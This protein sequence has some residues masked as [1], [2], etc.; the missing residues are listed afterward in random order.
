MLIKCI[1][2]SQDPIEKI[3][4]YI[5]F[6]DSG[7]SCQSGYSDHNFDD[8][9]PSLDNNGLGYNNLTT[10]VLATAWLFFQTEIYFM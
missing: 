1:L 9:P 4:V 10:M 3:L 5:G 7:F 8:E 2:S 6:C